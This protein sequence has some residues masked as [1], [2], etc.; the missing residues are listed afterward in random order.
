MLVI[1]TAP[2]PGCPPG[3]GGGVVG[4]GPLGGRLGLGVWH[5]AGGQRSE[6][7]ELAG[8]LAAAWGP[9]GGTDFKR[10]LYT[11]G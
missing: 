8:R 6:A 4:I 5:W 9:G 2:P 10:L 11:C 7:A 1:T 3:G